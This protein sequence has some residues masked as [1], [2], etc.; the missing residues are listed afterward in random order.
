MRAAVAVAVLGIGA[1]ASADP[2]PVTVELQPVE[3]VFAA[4][5]TSDD[6]LVAAT[7][8]A[9]AREQ[10]ASD[11]FAKLKVTGS[12][13]AVA[14]VTV[15][16]KGKTTR[17]L[18]GG[19]GDAKLEK[20]LE[21]AL[22]PTAWP[23]TSRGGAIVLT[24]ANGKG[25]Q[26]STATPDSSDMVGELLEPG[27]KDDAGALARV[28]T[29]GSV[30]VLIAEGSIP[31]YGDKVVPLLRGKTSTFKRCY[32]DALKSNPNLAGRLEVVFTIGGDGK[33]LAASVTATLSASVDACVT[34]AIK[35]LKFP[36]PP[37]GNALD[38]KLPLKFA[39]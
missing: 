39:P 1:A 26:A 11:C 4:A 23:A 15:D 22:K 3:L 19:T 7:G 32:T 30:D 21:K 10:A 33:V 24:I 31:G 36:S 13:N 14:L 9:Q 8:A 25:P 2:T 38:I 18:V 35:S 12:A 37:D 5:D 20:C 6:L 34:T 29:G 28:G 17:L 16:K 27:K